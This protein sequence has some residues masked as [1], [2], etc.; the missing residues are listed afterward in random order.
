MDRDDKELVVA[1]VSQLLTHGP[2]LVLSAISAFK[3]ET[4]TVADIRALE[5]TKKPEEFFDEE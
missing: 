3:R 2:Q 4:W 1:L 5:I